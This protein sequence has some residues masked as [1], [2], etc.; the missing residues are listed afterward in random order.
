MPEKRSGVHQ[1][2]SVV[3]KQNIP[4]QN[5]RA[6]L[7]NTFVVSREAVSYRRRNGQ[8]RQQ[9]EASQGTNVAVFSRLQQ[10]RRVQLR[11]GDLGHPQESF[12]KLD[13]NSAR[14]GILENFMWKTKV[15]TI[16]GKIA[17]N[18]KKK[19]RDS[20]PDAG[21]ASGLPQL[22]KINGFLLH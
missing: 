21:E 11:S 14:V 17:L 22:A 2:N 20:G 10:L 13:A 15:A 9:R 8:G 3:P 16:G 6:D 18:Q 5:I 19:C 4:K 7:P 1:V 12:R